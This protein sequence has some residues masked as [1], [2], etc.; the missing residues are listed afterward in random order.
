MN[1]RDGFWWAKTAT[2]RP[3]EGGDGAKSGHENGSTP[4]RFGFQPSRREKVINMGQKISQNGRGHVTERD[5]VFE[6][7]KSPY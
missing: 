1:V 7:L 6:R 5:I 2:D 3:E 4:G